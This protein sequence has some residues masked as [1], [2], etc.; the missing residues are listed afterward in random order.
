MYNHLISRIL[1]ISCG[2]SLSFVGLADQ[3]NGSLSAAASSQAIW[4]VSCQPEGAITSSR[5]AFQIEGL[6]K[7]RKFTVE[8]TAIKHEQIASTVDYKAADKKPSAFAFDAAGDGDYQVTVSK[9]VPIGPQ[10]PSKLKGTML[11][12]LTAHCESPTGYHTRT[13]IRRG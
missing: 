10:T 8:A 1:F 3:Q 4:I 9:K 12:A 5:L 13:T 6:T 2:I 7:G 11:Y